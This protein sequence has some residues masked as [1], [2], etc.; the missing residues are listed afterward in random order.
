MRVKLRYPSPPP[1][2]RNPGIGVPGLKCRFLP[3]TLAQPFWFQA[4]TFW[5]P[6]SGENIR[7]LFATGNLMDVEQLKKILRL[8]MG[9]MT[10]HE[11]YE[12]TGRIINITVSPGS[13]YETPRL[14][15]YLTAPDI[16]IWSA[17]CASC[18][19]PGL[20]PGV[21]LVRKDAGGK[22][23]PYFTKPIVWTD[24][25]LHSDLPTAKLQELFNV[26]YFIVS[27]TNPH[28][29][30]FFSQFFTSHR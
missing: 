11:A 7:R 1:H 21:E 12:K 8:N 22:M 24:G 4:L 19:L 17:S 6:N 26:N 15:N 2:S 10:F 14:L 23:L 28:A 5:T 13:R 27:Q 25:S 9:D 16:V 30:P 18:A 3:S 20:F 29:L